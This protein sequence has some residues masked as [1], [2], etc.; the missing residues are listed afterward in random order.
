MPK[1][2][3]RN[4]LVTP[5]WWPGAPGL[6]GYCPKARERRSPRDTC[7]LCCFYIRYFFLPFSPDSVKSAKSLT[8]S[9]RRSRSEQCRRPRQS[10]FS[11]SKFSLQARLSSFERSVERRW[12]ARVWAEAPAVGGAWSRALG[13]AVLLSGWSVQSWVARSDDHGDDASFRLGKVQVPAAQ[14]FP[15]IRH[16][17]SLPHTDSS[18]NAVSRRHGEERQIRL[19]HMCRI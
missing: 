10:I 4:D 17:L 13:A 6:L 12:M 2:G 19:T 5:V 11:T 16:T 15:R 8:V 1:S 3:T 7:R 14:D 18:Q 9:I